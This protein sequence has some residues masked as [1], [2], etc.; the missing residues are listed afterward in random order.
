[1]TKYVVTNNEGQ[2]ILF[3]HLNQPIL[4]ETE[5][6]AWEAAAADCDE[7]DQD[8]MMRVKEIE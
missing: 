3:D 7:D 6:L 1:M 4:F 5:E 8:Y 2:V